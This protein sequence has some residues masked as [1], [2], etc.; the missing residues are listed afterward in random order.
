M[1]KL[2]AGAR[3]NLLNLQLRLKYASMG[4]SLRLFKCNSLEGQ[5]Y[6]TPRPVHVHEYTPHLI[7]ITKQCPRRLLERDSQQNPGP[8]LEFKNLPI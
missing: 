7:M 2:I 1:L 8:S 6:S 4:L 3:C 5:P